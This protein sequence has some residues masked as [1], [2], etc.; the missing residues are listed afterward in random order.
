MHFLTKLLILVTF[1][2]FGEGGGGGFIGPM[3][4]KCSIEHVEKYRGITLLSVVG[5]LFTSILNAHLNSW[6]EQ[7]HIYIKAQSGFRKGMSTV[8]NCFMLQSL[9]SHC[10]NTNKKLYAA[11]VDIKKK[12]LTMWQEMFYGIN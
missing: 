10:S 11:F 5:K 3:L 12:R 9:I 2:I 7:Y 6:A 8:D 4:K 1:R